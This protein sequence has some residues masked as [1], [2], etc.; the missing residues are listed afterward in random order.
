MIKI[1]KNR[2]LYEVCLLKK[3]DERRSKKM[4][5][6]EIFYFGLSKL[7]KVSGTFEVDIAIK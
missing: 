7:L 5:K 1:L 4:N 3:K 2:I 6:I